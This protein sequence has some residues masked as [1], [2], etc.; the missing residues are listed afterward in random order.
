MP[1]PPTTLGTQ[2]VIDGLPDPYV[3]LRAV[4]DGAGGAT[5]LEVAAANADG[6]A[7]VAELLTSAAGGATIRER[8]LTVLETGGVIS[9]ADHPLATGAGDATGDDRRVEVHLRPAGDGVAVSWRDVTDQWHRR[10]A[11]EAAE[12]RFRMIAEHSTDFV[13]EVGPD[14]RIAWV[15]PSVTA[16]TGWRP[17]QLVG[18]NATDLGPQGG[19]AEV[20]GTLRPT[21]D[22]TPVARRIRF[23]LPDGGTRW[24]FMR[25]DPVLGPDGRLERIVAGFHDIQA[26]VEA[27]TALAEREAGY[28][29]LAD[30]ASDIVYRGRSDGTLDWVSPSVTEILGWAPD[31]LLG[32]PTMDLAHPDDRAWVAEQGRRLEAGAPITFEARYRHRDGTYRWMSVASRAF[33]DGQGRVAGR[34]GSLRD[35]TALR[36]AQDRIA[37]FNA[38]LEQRVRERTEELETF[39]STISHDLRT[40]LRWIDGFAGLLARDEADRLDE[41]GRHHLQAIRDAAQRMGRLADALLEWARIGR[42]QVRPGPI[43]WPTILARVRS[44]LGEAAW[45]R[46]DAAEP[47]AS[48]IGDPELVRRVLVELIQNAIE[49]AGM[50][51]GGPGAP[52]GRVVLTAAPDGGMVRVAV[53][54]QGTGIPAEQLANLFEPFARL[55]PDDGAPTTRIGLTLAQRAARMMGTSL[56]VRSSPGQGATF[57]FRLPPTEGARPASASGSEVAPASDAAQGNVIR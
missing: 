10:Q 9:L 11:S 31:E 48:A 40:P 25:I 50:V 19:T 7:G 30:N 26:A 21:R 2:E 54:D 43:A 28:R 57:S 18:M 55:E 35:I 42:H 53:T 6:R 39:T 46:V 29:L 36:E 38:T 27:E 3:L 23:R 24:M 45:A 13:A 14:W 15:S 33:I 47:L 49:H 20:V 8:C 32:R 44:S 12:R 16:L 1:R 5:D 51:A 4:R 37:A 56:E 41:T 22:G 34:T 52:A 17:E